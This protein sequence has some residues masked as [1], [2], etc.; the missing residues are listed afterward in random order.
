MLQVVA[1]LKLLLNKTYS[2]RELIIIE[3]GE[4]FYLDFCT[5]TSENQQVKNI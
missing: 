2:S 5:P 4:C 1:Q 3:R